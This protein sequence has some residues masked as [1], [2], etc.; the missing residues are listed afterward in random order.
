MILEHDNARPNTYAA[1][2][3]AIE[4]TGIEVVPRHSYSRI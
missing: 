2:S 1:T 3:A 4:K